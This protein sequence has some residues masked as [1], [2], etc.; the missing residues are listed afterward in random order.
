MAKIADLGVAKAIG[1]NQATKPHS[2]TPG[3]LQFMPPET[4]SVEPCYGKPVDVF[5]LACIT[6]HVMS[7]QWP[8]PRDLLQGSSFFAR[9]EVQR[10]EHYLELCTPSS[11]R[12]LVESCLHNE[13]GERPKISCL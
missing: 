10:R 1:H 2:Q 8:Q 4:M 12:L 13:P 11:L 9:T 5:S 7:H 6:L 3:T